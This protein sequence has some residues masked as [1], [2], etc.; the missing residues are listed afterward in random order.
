MSIIEMSNMAV[1]Y[2]D[3]L[4]K[5][6]LPQGWEKYVATN[7]QSC[8]FVKSDYEPKE[9]EA[10]F[11]LQTRNFQTLCQLY[12]RGDDLP[13][14]DAAEGDEPGPRFT[15]EAMDEELKWKVTDNDHNITMVFQEG[16]ANQTQKVTTPKNLS[17]DDILNVPKWMREMGDWIGLYC[18]DEALCDVEV[19]S[20]VIATLDK[21]GYWI[22]LAAALN[23]T[24]TSDTTEE[25]SIHQNVL[26]YAEIEDY[27]LDCNV[28]WLDE[29][30]Q[31]QLLSILDNFD[32]NEANEVCRIIR[33]YWES[34]RNPNEWVHQL[35]WWPSFVPAALKENEE[36][37]DK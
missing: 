25:S 19:R 28:P 36:K 29:E 32:E 20:Y 26:L 31:K 11:Y 4:K 37:T 12:K 9:N 30:E 15:I 24:I 27:M 33:A 22:T 13:D 7:G 23:G 18:T 1:R 5:K 35:L 2:Y 6:G 3:S 10:V 21:E 8:I 34:N 14:A 16:L 17:Q